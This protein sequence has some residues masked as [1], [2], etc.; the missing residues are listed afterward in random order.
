MEALGVSGR[1]LGTDLSMAAPGMH[2]VDQPLLVPKARGLDY[3]P[4]IEEIVREHN[5]GLLVPLTDLDLRSLARKRRHFQELGCEIMIGTDEIVSL[6]RD[7]QKFAAL[8]ESAGL[9]CIRTL[10]LGEFRKDPFFPCF[11]K[12]ISGSA[13]VG[14]ARIDSNTKLK[15]HIH[16]F[17]EQLIVQDYVPGR[18]YT[19]DVYR[20][21]DGVIHT[22]IPRQRLLV[23][24]G[25]VENG[26]T[27]DDAE[28]VDTA[29]RVVN[30]LDGL[31]GA[32]C[33][34]CRR[35]RGEPPRFFEVNPRFGGGTPLSI[36]AGAELPR[37][38]LEEIL[39]RP[40]SARADGYRPNTVM[41]RYAEEVFTTC[42]TPGDLP[43][44]ESP[45]FK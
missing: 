19:I 39:G 2:V 36:A 12:P 30:L 38:L 16:I 33:L 1:L 41:L 31:W 26:V 17:G 29:H 6:C 3:M 5:I 14:T 35:P 27:V 11:L 42:E 4:R 34:Q 23:R 10:S 24:S 20:S 32:F 13:G 37:Y 7:K 40:I 22:V 43:G 9:P 21:R 25:E 28:L 8:L 45:I 44:F 15:Q 18:E